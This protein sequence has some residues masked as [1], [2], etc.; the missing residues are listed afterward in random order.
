VSEAFE[1]FVH[2]RRV[3][4]RE[5][6]SKRAHVMSPRCTT[7]VRRWWSSPLDHR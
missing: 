7:L 6:Q 3:A 5:R 1:C 4:D 2:R